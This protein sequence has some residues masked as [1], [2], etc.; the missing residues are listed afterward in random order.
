MSQWVFNS[1]MWVVTVK[2]H[3]TE[4]ASGNGERNWNL[5]QSFFVLAE[6]YTGNKSETFWYI[7][8]WK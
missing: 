3:I 2:M 1:L 7:T 5:R 6:Q 8:M 4:A